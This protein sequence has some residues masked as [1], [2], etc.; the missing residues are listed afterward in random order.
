MVLHGEDFQLT[1]VH[2]ILHRVNGALEDRDATGTAG[3]LLVDNVHHRVRDDVASRAVGAVDIKAF[4]LT[5]GSEVNAVMAT[6]QR[7]VRG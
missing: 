2:I 3:P 7:N 6:G 4:E 5:V 1:N